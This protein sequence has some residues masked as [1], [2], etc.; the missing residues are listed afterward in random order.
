VRRYRYD[1]LHVNPSFATVRAALRLVETG[2]N[3]QRARGF[4]NASEMVRFWTQAEPHG[5]RW[6]NPTYRWQTSRGT[7]TYRS[8]REGAAMM[9]CAWYVDSGLTLHV[10]V[11]GENIQADSAADLRAECQPWGLS[12]LMDCRSLPITY[13]YPELWI[14]PCLRGLKGLE[15]VLWRACAECPLDLAAWMALGDHITDNWPDG[16]G[17]AFAPAVERCRA[18]VARGMK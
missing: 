14:N 9:G 6:S 5:I 4:L 10:R 18:L 13:V 15:K 7:P 16:A 2:V 17:E 1:Y 3:A 8:W 11:V 12:A